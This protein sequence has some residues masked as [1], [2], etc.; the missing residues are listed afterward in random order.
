MRA[1]K[2]FI[3]TNV[4]IYAF[5]SDEPQKQEIALKFLDDCQPVIS[6]QVL[7]EFANIVLKKGNI[8]FGNVKETISEITEIADVIN[9]DLNL[10]IDSVDIHEQYKY[11]FYDSLIIAAALSA[12]CQ[13]LLS[14]DMQSEQIIY[15]KL[16]IVSPF[17]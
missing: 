11:S 4:L 9:E 5:T 3:D 17:R 8:S 13:I 1:A 16:R 12:Q 10:I 15:D 14:E 6:T 2:T 7:K